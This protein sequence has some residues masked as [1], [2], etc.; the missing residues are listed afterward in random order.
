[1]RGQNV[2]LSFSFIS[3]VVL[4][5]LLL[6]INL[7]FIL[8][9][10]YLYFFFSYFLFVLIVLYFEVIPSSRINDC[11]QKTIGFSGGAHFSFSDK[12]SNFTCDKKNSGKFCK[13]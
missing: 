10:F 5:L 4:L 12:D 3:V 8:I 2:Y 13:G 9:I 7:S 11:L 6:L 1:M